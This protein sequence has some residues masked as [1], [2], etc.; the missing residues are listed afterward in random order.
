MRNSTSEFK[1]L[2]NIA[3]TS[4][5]GLML[6]PRAVPGASTWSYGIARARSTFGAI[7]VDDIIETTERPKVHWHRSGWTSV[8]LTGAQLRPAR[9]KFDR[10]PD[11]R[12]AQVASVIVGRPWAFP[13][14]PLRTG[15]QF[16]VVDSWPMHLGV[17]L[18]AYFVPQGANLD[19]VRSRLPAVGLIDGD[20]VRT[21]VDLRG[22]DLDAFLVFRYRASD[23]LADAAATSI[24]AGPLRR[25]P[26]R[27]T[28]Y[29]ALWSG[30][31]DNPKV[32]ID[33]PPPA[34]VF[35]GEGRTLDPA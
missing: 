6:A 21:V 27:S 12:A 24:M 1:P 16:Y 2:V 31:L 9:V 8:S 29:I 33:E 4:D 5:G 10:L 13:T 25:R 26:R 30:N 19:I 3:T 35:L 17:E 18:Y 11:L 14:E 7:G 20:P 22:H 15:D 23:D 34:A 32:T 28:R